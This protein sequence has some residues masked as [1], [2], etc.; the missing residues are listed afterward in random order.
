[1]YTLFADKEKEII[2]DLQELDIAVY[3]KNHPS[4]ANEKYDV[5]RKEFNFNFLEG[6]G[7][8]LPDVDLVFSYDSTLAYEYASIGT[9][10]LYYNNFD[11]KDVKRIVE[12]K[13][14]YK[15]NGND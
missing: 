14:T 9:E 2:K 11:M 6:V 12:K 13:L 1:M 8:E 15:S 10:V 3:L 5:L 7:A 4:I